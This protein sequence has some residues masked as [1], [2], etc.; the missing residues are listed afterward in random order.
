MPP[1][2][3]RV[4]EAIPSSI[5]KLL[6]L[7]LL[8]VVPPALTL[9]AFASLIKALSCGSDSCSCS[10]SLFSALASKPGPRLMSELF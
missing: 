8:V 2:G 10:W 4:L 6:L 7:L 3:L 9:V 5:F 1:N